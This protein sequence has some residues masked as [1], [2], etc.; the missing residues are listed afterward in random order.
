MIDLTPAV[1]LYIKMK[2][3]KSS[4]LYKNFKTRQKRNSL[5]KTLRENLPYFSKLWLFS[6]FILLPVR[7]DYKW[8]P[9]KCV[10]YPRVCLCVVLIFKIPERYKKDCN[11]ILLFKK[12][13][14]LASGDRLSQSLSFLPQKDSRLRVRD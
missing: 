10:I 4:I 3:L 2:Q 14:I 11:D 5:L 9:F 1:G 6:Y 12:P 7:F 13:G 8:L